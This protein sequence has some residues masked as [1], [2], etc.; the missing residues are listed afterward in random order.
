MIE[1]LTY[2]IVIVNENID[3]IVDLWV[4]GDFWIKTLFQKLITKP[5]T[6]EI[7]ATHKIAKY[8]SKNWIQIHE[9]NNNKII[10]KIIFFS[11]NTS[12][13]FLIKWAHNAEKTPVIAKI[14]QILSILNQIC[15]KYGWYVNQYIFQI[16]DIKDIITIIYSSNLFLTIKCNHSFICVLVSNECDFFCHQSIIKNNIIKT[17]I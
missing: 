11:V 13:I 6:I 17:K 5:N 8:I 1:K 12:C 9:I 10:I 15:L 2:Q 7:I 14:I 4:F 16:D 3:K